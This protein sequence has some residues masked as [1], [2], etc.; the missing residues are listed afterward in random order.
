MVI[1]CNEKGGNRIVFSRRV[2]GST[3]LYIMNKDGTGATALPGSALGVD[4]DPDW[5]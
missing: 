1:L 5:R 2:G 3:R 4:N